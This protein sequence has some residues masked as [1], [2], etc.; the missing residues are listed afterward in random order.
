MPFTVSGHQGQTIP[1]ACSSQLR[2]YCTDRGQTITVQYFKFIQFHKT[3]KQRKSHSCH[4][5]LCFHIVISNL[6]DV[7][8]LVSHW[9]DHSDVT[10]K[11]LALTQ[12][13]A[14]HTTGKYP[15]GLG[16]FSYWQHLV[17]SNRKAMDWFTPDFCFKQVGHQTVLPS[18]LKCAHRFVWGPPGSRQAGLF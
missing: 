9:P 7:Y 17:I 1:Y 2:P 14:A 11:T 10:L 16:S 5:T 15:G 4:L 13:K 12:V 18:K 6:V 8:L 3:N